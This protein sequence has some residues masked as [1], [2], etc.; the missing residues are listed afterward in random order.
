M[1]EIS[2]PVRSYNV[3]T[4]RLAPT[5]VRGEGS[6]A[7][8]LLVLPFE[9]QMNPTKGERGPVSYTLLRL[10]GTLII[11]AS[12]AELATFEFQPLAAEPFPDPGYWPLPIAVELDRAVI[13]HFEEARAGADARL[14]ISLAALISFP[15]NH[16][17]EAVRSTTPLLI[18]VPRSHWVD[19]VLSRWNLTDIKLIEI[20][21]P[22]SAAG[23]NYRT[24]YERVETAEKLFANGLYREALT[25]LRRAFE[26]LAQSHNFGK[27]YELFE[28]VFG[29]AHPDK[30]EKATQALT[31][32]YRFLHLGPH[33]PSRNEQA[34]NPSEPTVTRRDAR[35]ALTMVHAIFEYMTPVE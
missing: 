34:S 31:H 2:F 12:G 9:I 11:P 20:R 3:L 13:R 27:P 19:N 16:K 28:H 35:F 23:E 17:F 32:M 1:S 22:K 6:P 30:R 18:A 4:V 7:R 25:E 14:S 21:F 26:A 8:P 29:D 33:E 5:D 15:D 24:A 10:A